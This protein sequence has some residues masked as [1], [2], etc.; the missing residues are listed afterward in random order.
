MACGGL[1]AR[2]LRKDGI[3]GVRRPVEGHGAQETLKI[4]KNTQFRPTMGVKL[5]VVSVIC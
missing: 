2:W 3:G 1:L 4:Y 5:G